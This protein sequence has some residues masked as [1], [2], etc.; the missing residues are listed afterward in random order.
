MVSTE[1]TGNP[2]PLEVTLTCLL[3]DTGVF[4]CVHNVITFVNRHVTPREGKG[5]RILI[6][7]LEDRGTAFIPY[8]HTGLI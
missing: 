3:V 7:R 5:N 1:G 2:S 4:S 8:P 6:I